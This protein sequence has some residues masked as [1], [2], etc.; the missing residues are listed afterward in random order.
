MR[1]RPLR[2]GG[3][4]RTACRRASHSTSASG[5]V[6]GAGLS[7]RGVLWQARHM[8]DFNAKEGAELGHQRV[9]LAS[10]RGDVH[11]S[12]PSEEQRST[13]VQVRSHVAVGG[14]ESSRDRLALSYPSL[15]RFAGE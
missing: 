15:E 6:C 7:P 11:R 3:L 13:P 12:P 9:G 5:H 14:A 8:A 1:N 4:R 2:L 10:C